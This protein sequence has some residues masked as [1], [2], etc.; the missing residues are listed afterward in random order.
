MAEPDFSSPLSLRATRTFA[1]SRERVFRAWTE[2]EAVRRWF[3]EPSEGRWTEA[4]QIDARPGGRYRLAG[5]SGGKPWCV[6]GTYRE[7]KPPERLVFTWEWDDYP[8]PGESGRTLV[9]VEFLERG[10]RTELVLT[11]EGFPHESS[12]DEHSQG[13]TGCFD[14]IERLLSRARGRRRRT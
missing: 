3:I 6:Y 4:P 5:E 12:R 11:H 8:N 14:A 7:V 2:A 10:Q 1:A 9:T 13:W